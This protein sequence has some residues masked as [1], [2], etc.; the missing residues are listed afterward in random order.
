MKQGLHDITVIGGGW[1][2]HYTILPFSVIEK[3]YYINNELKFLCLLNRPQ[4]SL[5]TKA[6]AVSWFPRVLSG[7]NLVYLT[8]STNILLLKI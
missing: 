1:G 6:A 4:S 5:C 3:L 2:V 7:G 8:N